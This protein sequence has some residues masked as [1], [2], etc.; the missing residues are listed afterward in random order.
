LQQRRRPSP[1]NGVS[2]SPIS[3]RTR[4]WE[5]I[6][7][8]GQRPA[9]TCTQITGIQWMRQGSS[10]AELIDPTCRP[11]AYV[12]RSRSHNSGR[13]CG[14]R[15]LIDDAAGRAPHPLRF[16]GMLEQEGTSYSFEFF[17]PKDDAGE[18]TLWEAIRHLERVRPTFVSV[19]YGAGG[20]TVNARC[21]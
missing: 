15:N 20:S 4:D 6:S 12:R 17:P 18:R 21:G 11:V 2:S 10:D 19:T 3:D 13:V 5:E 8:V 9:H 1:T 14:T 7:A 16:R